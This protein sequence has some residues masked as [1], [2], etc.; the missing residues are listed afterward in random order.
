MRTER[1]SGSVIDERSQAS[2]F[3]IP[4]MI[5]R[6][7]GRMIFLI[8]YA[9]KQ[10]VLTIALS[11]VARLSLIGLTKTLSNELAPHN[12]LVNV[13]MPGLTLTERM[14]AL[15]EMMA[16]SRGLTYEQALKELKGKC[17]LGE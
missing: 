14:K 8:S 15:V 5:E 10:P 7:W 13:V 2:K 9:V 1:G 4:Y 17:H 11:N 6:K 16:R 3:L 12:I